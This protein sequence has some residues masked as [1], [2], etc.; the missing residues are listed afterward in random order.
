MPA[1]RVKVGLAAAATVAV[2]AA[3]ALLYPPP[4][5][6]HALV[7]KQ[8]LAIP[9]WLFAWGASLVL[10]VSFIALTVAWRDTYF[11]SEHWRPAP[12]WLSR[13]I[14]NP[15]TD[16]AAGAIGA[17][18]LGVVLW[19]G[20]S[21]VEAPDQNFSVTFVFVTFW[22]GLVLVS[23]LLGDV[24]RAFNPWRA[25]A[26]AFAGVFRGVTRQEAPSPLAYPERLGR[27]PAVV[28]LVAF[29]WLELIYSE[30]GFGAVG[31]TPRTLAIAVLV[32]STIT[33]VGMALY[34]IETW[35]DRGEA[36]SVYFGMFSRL[37]P[38]EVRDGRLGLRRPLSGATR[39]AAVPGS[40]AVVLVAIGGTAFDG[41]QEG[42]L[43]DPINEVFQWMLD[44]GVGGTLAFR[45]TS[46]LF[47]ALTLAFV[48]GIFWLGVRGMRTVRGTSLSLDGLGRAFAH[49]FIPIALAYLTAHYFSLAIFQGQ[50]QFT[51]L[52]TDPLGDGSNLFGIAKDPIDYGLIGATAVWYV[53]VG[54]LVAGHVTGLVLAHDKAIAV[55]ED[56][57]LAARSQYW[58]LALM[59]GFTCLGLFL[60]SQAN[61]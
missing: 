41:A 45:L 36:F 28:G 15:V 54:A 46:S 29:L 12:D 48:A 23:I 3:A 2:A 55:Y 53:Q 60:L 44:Q 1:V 58:M 42:L 34:G 47:L 16:V 21:G 17:F 37:A 14:V 51:F 25:I 33:L 40:V 5:A 56:P 10:I 43:S 49:G 30:S 61:Q 39:W 20:L 7:G 35:L 24:F 8:D 59:V 50:A 11:E 26:R 38:F 31:L 52:L 32:Y 18:L 22:L 4:A 57:R 6:A 13:T 9:E 27:W 19:S